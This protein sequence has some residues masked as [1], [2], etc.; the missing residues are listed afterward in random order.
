MDNFLVNLLKGIGFDGSNLM[1]AYKNFKEWAMQVRHIESDN[2]IMAVPRKKDGTLASTAKG[3]YQFTDSSVKT[4]K[5]RLK[6]MGYD[7]KVI[8][9]IS[10]NPQDWS[11]DEADA[12]FFGN[13][14]A[15]KGS[16]P[17]LQEIGLGNLKTRRDAYYSFHHTKPDTATINRAESFI[18]VENDLMDMTMENYNRVNSAFS[19][20]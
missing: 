15:Q 3:V 1:N 2:R 17:M 10:N 12:M 20:R 5:R 18:P 16:D 6:N 9:S 11:D 7:K 19:E 14:F 8:N 4:A 13:I